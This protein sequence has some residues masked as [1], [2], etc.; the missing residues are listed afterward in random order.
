MRVISGEWRGRRL[1][2]PEGRGT[3][4]PTTDRVREAMVSML[5]SAVD[6]EFEGL[7]VLDAFGGTGALGIELLSRGAAH[8][9]FY[10]QDRRAAALISK[11]LSALKA[12]PTRWQVLCRDVMAEASRGRVSGGP[13]DIVLLDPPYAYGAEPV[14]RLLQD[15]AGRGMLSAGA[16]ALCEHAAADAGPRPEGF[17][18]LRE[19]R[20][21]ITACDLLELGSED[22]HDL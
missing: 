1:I 15:L 3:T 2:E 11:N 13:F 19:K 16:L 22:A 14:K 21:G 10:D 9:T 17:R 18:V 6:F 20:Y 12:A 4:R 5:A 8:A 7:R